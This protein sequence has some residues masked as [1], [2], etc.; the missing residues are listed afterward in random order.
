M[1]AIFIHA[2]VSWAALILLFL[3]WSLFQLHRPRAPYWWRKRQAARIRAACASTHECSIA[4]CFHS[5]EAAMIFCETHGLVRIVTDP[6]VIAA[7]AAMV[8]TRKGGDE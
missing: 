3:G 5:D 4:I 1:R 6:A 2:I 7:Y 8:R